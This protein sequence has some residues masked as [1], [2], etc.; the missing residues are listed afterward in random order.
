MTDRMTLS[1]AAHRYGIGTK[2]LA[3]RIRTGAMPSTR[4]PHYQSRHYV[5]AEDVEAWVAK[6]RGAHRVGSNFYRVAAL[7]ATGMSNVSIAEYLGISRERVRQLV[8]KAA[9][10]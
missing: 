9:K 6:P 7:R 5:T 4:N 1:Q 8:L 2:A 3:Y 10:G